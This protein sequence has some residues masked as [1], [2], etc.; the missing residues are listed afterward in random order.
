MNFA[1]YR[2]ACLDRKTARDDAKT[3]RDYWRA[4]ALRQLGMVAA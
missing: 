1:E 3:E 4:I 2:Q